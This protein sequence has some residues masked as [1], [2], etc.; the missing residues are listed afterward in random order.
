[1]TVSLERDCMISGYHWYITHHVVYGHCM[2]LRVCWNCALPPPV[3]SPAAKVMFPKYE[4]CQVTP[5]PIPGT[6]L[7]LRI[8]SLVIAESFLGAPSPPSNSFNPTL[9][10]T[11]LPSLS[12]SDMLSSFLLRAFGHAISLLGTLFLCPANPPHS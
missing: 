3:S 7:A 11:F 10:Q 9:P 4:P 6:P 8:K 1:M 12:F 2:A 5:L